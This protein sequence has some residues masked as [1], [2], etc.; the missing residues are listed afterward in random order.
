MAHPAHVSSAEQT[1]SPHTD[2]PASA[3]PMTEP[4]V[5][6]S[7]PASAP[8]PNPA[9]DDPDAPHPAARGRKAR[10]EAKTGDFD[11]MRYLRGGAV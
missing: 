4:P 2:G 11:V 5:D 8:P 1:R 6:P 7:A 10:I 3:E 9:S